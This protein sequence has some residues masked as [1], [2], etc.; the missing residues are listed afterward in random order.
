VQRD[1]TSGGLQ[2]FGRASRDGQPVALAEAPAT[3]GIID[4]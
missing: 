2:G 3:L 4:V 1:H